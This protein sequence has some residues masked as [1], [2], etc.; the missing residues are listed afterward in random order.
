VTKRGHTK[1]LD[2]G[3]A[4][5]AVTASSATNIAAAGTQTGSPDIQHLTSPGSTPGTVA[6]MS[7]EQGRGKE[8]D[9]RIDRV[10]TIHTLL[11]HDFHRLADLCSAGVQIP[12]EP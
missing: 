9:P 4:R 12:L 3:L 11:R 1:I 10:L 2:F 5:V 8:L 7:P 6:Y